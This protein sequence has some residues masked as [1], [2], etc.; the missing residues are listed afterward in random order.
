M[1]CCGK[2]RPTEGSATLEQVALGC[3]RK[4]AVKASKQRS[5]M[6][7]ASAPASKSLLTFLWRLPLTVNCDVNHKPSELSP[8]RAALVEVF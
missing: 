6:V 7:S 2:A 8:P 4:K 1:D 3:K 5:S